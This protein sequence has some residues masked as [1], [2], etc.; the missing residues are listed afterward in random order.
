METL[1]NNSNNILGT[2]KIPGSERFTRPEEIKA[3][4]KYLKQVHNIQDEHTN[5]GEESLALFGRKSGKLVNIEKL[6]DHEYLDKISDDNQLSLVDGARP[7]LDNE[8][9]DVIDLLQKKIQLAESENNPDIKLVEDNEKLKDTD[10]ELNLSNRPI[11]ILP[12]ET[13]WTNKLVNDVVKLKRSTEDPTLNTEKI[14]L[15]IP[16]KVTPLS[17]ERL[18]LDD[19]KTIQSLHQYQELDKLDADEST[20]LST[21]REDLVDHRDIQLD[22]HI[23]EIQDNRVEKLD[24]YK[25]NISDERTTYLNKDKVELEGTSREV[26]LNTEKEDLEVEDNLY[27]LPTNL[28]KISDA[29]SQINL[30]NYRDDIE[31]DKDIK[32]LPE[33]RESLEVKEELE[34]LPTDKLT[35]EDK[36]DPS[37]SDYRES[38]NV[39][40]VDSLSNQRIDIKADDEI[41]LPEE[42]LKIKPDN[43]FD[44]LP[45]KKENILNNYGLSEITKLSD[46]KDSLLVNQNTS[47]EDINLSDYKENLKDDRENSLSTN[48]E[49]LLG[50]KPDVTL[51]EEAVQIA[52]GLN[53][54]PSTLED[55][56]VLLEPEEKVT[57]LDNSSVKLNNTEESINQLSDFIENLDLNNTV[58][59]GLTTKKNKEFQQLEN[60]QELLKTGRKVSI[61]DLEDAI[62]VI[63]NDT[64]KPINE[65]P[66]E[67][68]KLGWNKNPDASSTLVSDEFLS[69]AISAVES[70]RGLTDT[71]LF[72]RIMKL[73]QDFRSSTSVGSSEWISKTESL[74]TTYFDESNKLKVSLDKNDNNFIKN[75]IDSITIGEDSEFKDYYKLSRVNNNHSEYDLNVPISENTNNPLDKEVTIKNEDGKVVGYSSFLTTLLDANSVNELEQ[76]LNE[77]RTK[78]DNSINLSTPKSTDN[79]FYEK[80]KEREDV[81]VADS[82]LIVKTIDKLQEDINSRKR[83]EENSPNI[84]LPESNKDDRDP[85]DDR[86]SLVDDIIKSKTLEELQERVKKEGSKGKNGLNSIYIEEEFIRNIIR[87]IRIIKKL[88]PENPGEVYKRPTHKK[89]VV[90]G[91]ILQEIS[92]PDPLTDSGLPTGVVSRGEYKLP[93]YVP[94]TWVDVKNLALDNPLTMITNPGTLLNYNKYLRYVAEIV[95][96]Y[97]YGQYSN[98]KDSIN[99]TKSKSDFARGIGNLAEQVVTNYTGIPTNKRRML[100]ETLAMLVYMRDAAEM[101]LKRDRGRLPGQSN[102]SLNFN[103]GSKSVSE[104]LLAKALNMASSLATGGLL[105]PGGARNRPAAVKVDENSNNEGDGN[106]GVINKVKSALSTAKKATQQF[107]VPSLVPKKTVT[108]VFSENGRRTDENYKI[109][110]EYF[111]STTR[112][113]IEVAERFKVPGVLTTLSELADWDGK[114][115]SSLEEFKEILMKA[116]H[117]TTPGKFSS[118]TLNGYKSQTLSSNS[119]WEVI[120]EPF[121]HSHMNGGFSYLPSIRE[122]NVK[123]L[124][125]HGIYTGYNEWLPITS[126]ELERAKL[127]TKS[128]GLYEGEI[129]YPVGCEFLN[130]LTITMINDSL[131]SWSGF[132]RT[133]MDVSTHNSEPHKADFYKEDSPTPT[134]IDYSAPMIALYKNITW[135]CKIYILSPQFSTIKKFDLLVVLKDYTESYSGDIDSPGSDVQLRFSIVGENPP[136]DDGILKPIVFTPEPEINNNTNETEVTTTE[137]TTEPK[138]PEPDKGTQEEQPDKD[139]TSTTETSKITT[140]TTT[141]PPKDDKPSGSGGG[142]KD[143][144][145]NKNTKSKTPPGTG[146]VYY[147]VVDIP[148]YNPED[149]DIHR[150]KIEKRRGNPDTDPYALNFQFN[151][152]GSIESAYLDP[153]DRLN[154]DTY[155]N[156]STYEDLAYTDDLTAMGKL[157]Y[158]YKNKNKQQ[159]L[160]YMNWAD[161]FYSPEYMDGKEDRIDEREEQE[162]KETRDN[163]YEISH[164]KHKPNTYYRN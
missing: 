75:W 160:A 30:S 17:K 154:N 94:K 121:V 4:S 133:V 28:E 63:D 33:E 99:E 14:D 60:Y 107:F 123:N 61:S 6:S 13:N 125:D 36:G 124:K 119:Y 92:S 7:M 74:L 151:A 23:D 52:E 35:I 149:G 130:E 163:L 117:I 53:R 122:I 147:A 84:Y 50:E 38:I 150:F 138:S 58:E 27:N 76:L 105:S 141:D 87:N 65:L 88:D 80:W 37:L 114:S 95:S 115:I 106:K 146:N 93:T 47:S 153:S 77:F 41:E 64:R 55:G 98:S 67:K 157:K 96:D 59:A 156:G 85:S 91:G 144:K 129:V 19:N 152:D 18:D 40:E 116:P 15:D 42:S 104:K 22:N 10:K 132:W 45:D 162:R 135:R 137:P 89:K 103:G 113:V 140:Q 109:E 126:F 26:L 31:G 43:L 148:A 111:G 158:D 1:N 56:K 54:A 12:D 25:E 134:A 139:K 112:S 155:F 9:E 128:L 11:D 21:V 78:L 57:E 16:N 8:S 2:N 79:P 120:L 102:T 44:I 145:G 81:P 136:E 83:K 3:L 86:T 90:S 161:Y 39:S 34:S 159:N 73:L 48:K 69:K 143:N 110:R 66:D 131:K 5:L 142:N 68:E 97:L 49:K 82:D 164:R 29:I 71:H 118:T 51:E 72:N 100:E 127:T 20:P 46:T 32:N 24:N 108:Q 101:N 70:S 62:F